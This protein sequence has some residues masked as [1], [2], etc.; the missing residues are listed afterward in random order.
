MRILMPHRFLGQNVGGNS[1]YARTLAAGLRREG[2]EV[3]SFGVGMSRARMHAGE[4][5]APIWG[6]PAGTVLHYVAD[7]GL[8]LKSNVPS[9]VTVHGVASKWIDSARRPMQDRSWRMRV[10]RSLNAADRVITVSESSAADIASVFDVSRERI[11]I[12][13]HGIDTTLFDVAT[14]PSSS[15]RARISGTY[16]LYLGNI[17]PRKNLVSLVEAC[18]AI[19]PEVWGDRK[20][21]IAGRPAWNFQDSIDAFERSD[22]VVYLGF[23]DDADRRALMQ[24]AELFV[25]PS[26]Y[27]GF[28]FPVLEALSAGTPVVTTDKGSLRDLA[29]PAFQLKGTTPEHIRSGLVEAMGD[30]QWK[31][32]CSQAGPVWAQQFTWTESVAR[33]LAVYREVLAS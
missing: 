20:L 17:E 30:E 16:L 9:V 10:G 25:F 2:I 6:H 11:E 27:E 32:N 23:V 7:T 22:R 24:G 33:H 15:V 29:G 31:S 12:I 26:L 28:G 18:D 8:L 1:T 3:A 21:V 5:L 13:P 4:A 19:D 14:S